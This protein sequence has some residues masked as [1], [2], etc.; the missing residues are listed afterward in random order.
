M[1]VKSPNSDDVFAK[2]INKNP[3]KKLEKFFG[4]KGIKFEK[5][6]IAAGESIENVVK[7]A[8][9]FFRSE[10][11]YEV[12]SKTLTEKE[13]NQKG[14]SKVKFYSFPKNV[15]QI[16]WKGKNKVP[17]FNT[18]KE[19][20]C[21]KCDGL[22]YKGCKSCES[23]GLAKCNKC[24]GSGKVQCKKCKGSGKLPLKLEVLVGEKLEKQKK[25]MNYQCGECFGTGKITCK[26]CSGMGKVLCKKCKPNFGKAICKECKGTGK[27]Y[28][29]RIGSVPFQ[30]TKGEY[31]PHL[32]F[33]SEFEKKIG[34][35]LS[36]IITKVDGIYIKSL[37]DLNEDFVRAQLGYWDGEIKNRMNNAKN[38][39]KSLE[40]SKG[41]ETPKFPI[42]LFPAL[43]LSVK[44]NKGKTFNVYSI[45][46]ERGYEVF[47][48]KL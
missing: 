23:T 45:G 6:N 27:Y 48:P 1:S 37:K 25:S 32:F 18:I 26:T 14:L 12:D 46:T 41:P 39:F 29:Y 35:E 36:S 15:N 42:Y 20:N 3:A 43:K 21:K 10:V 8:V 28:T 9:F 31:V 40:K 11:S 24:D 19:V 16:N 38:E 22:G 44:T 7:S 13:V 34:Q 2:F 4:E 47:S 5:G 30:T 17:L 33:K